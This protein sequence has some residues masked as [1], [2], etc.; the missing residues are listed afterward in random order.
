MTLQE[1]FEGITDKRVKRCKK[2][3]LVDIL[4]IVFIGM[5]CGHKSP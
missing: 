3:N 4:M 1:S 5:L 2:H